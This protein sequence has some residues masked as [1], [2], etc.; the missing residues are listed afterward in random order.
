LIARSLFDRLPAGLRILFTV[1]AGALAAWLLSLVVFVGG[2]G[3]VIGFFTG[4]MGRSGGGGG[5]R[6]ARHHDWGGFGGGSSGGG[7][8]GGGGSSGGGWSGGGGMSGGGG[9]SGGW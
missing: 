4:L 9:A 8:W 1:A 3:A 5:G 7:G 6:Y 2:I